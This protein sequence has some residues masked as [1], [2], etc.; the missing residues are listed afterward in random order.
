MIWIPFV[1]TALKQLSKYLGID[2]RQHCAYHPSSGGAVERENGTLKNN[3]LNFMGKV[4]VSLVCSARSTFFNDKPV[5]W[6]F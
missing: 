5:Y 6:Q 2:L 4:S 3:W 1:S